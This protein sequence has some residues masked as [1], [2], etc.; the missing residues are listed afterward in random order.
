M[1]K[2]SNHTKCAD[3][4]PG[5]LYHKDVYM[6]SVLKKLA[7]NLFMQFKNNTKFNCTHISNNQDCDR[8]HSYDV[9]QIKEAISKVDASQINIFEIG[10]EY[11]LNDTPNMDIVK[12]G[13]RIPYND[14]EDVIIFYN[15]NGTV[16]TAWLNYKAD[17]HN[18][19][20]RS[21]YAHAPVA[22]TSKKHKKKNK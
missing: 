6:P 20:D 17:N 4:F 22:H 18:T 3:S 7:L 13:V 15:P 12:F 10:T 2:G 21:K 5:D 1:Y 16:R 8:C 19:L 9:D 11:S 14:N